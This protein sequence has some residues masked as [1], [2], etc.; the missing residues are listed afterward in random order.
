MYHVDFE[1]PKFALGKF[2]KNLQFCIVKLK[3]WE[4]EQE[5]T[6]GIGRNKLECQ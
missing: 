3:I 1:F 2:T 5:R 6:L 4:Y